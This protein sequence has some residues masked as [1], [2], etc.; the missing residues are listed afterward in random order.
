MFNWGT[1]QKNTNSSTQGVDKSSSTNKPPDHDDGT[2]VINYDQGTLL[3]KAIEER[4]WKSILSRISMSPHEVSTYV[5][6]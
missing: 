3:F 2:R 4:Q 1:N 5:Y 6:R